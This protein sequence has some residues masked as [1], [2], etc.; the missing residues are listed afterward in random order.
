MIA[1]PRLDRLAKEGVRFTDAYSAAPFCSPSRAALLTGRLP[2]RTNV[3][4]PIQPSDLANSQVSPYAT[5]LPK[6]LKQ[7]GYVNALIGKMHLSG[8][9]QNPPTNPMHFEAY[10]RLG[11]D[12]FNG[13]LDAAPLSVDTTAGG[14]APPKTT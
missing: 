8:N 3:L 10:R 13:Y 1:T 6:L 12:Y 14:V 4:N 2:A 9:E 5:T 11:F 7:K